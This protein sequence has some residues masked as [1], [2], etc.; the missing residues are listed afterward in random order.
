MRLSNIITTLEESIAKYGTNSFL[1]HQNEL[2]PSLIK[3]ISAIPRGS[4]GSY[5]IPSH[6]EERYEN[7]PIKP[8]V[9]SNIYN[10][11]HSYSITLFRLFKGS[12]MPLHDH[13]DISGINYLLSGDILHQS[14]DVVDVLNADKRQFVGIKYKETHLKENDVIVTLPHKENIHEFVANEN[15]SILQILVPDYDQ[16]QRRCSYW[17]V[18]NDLDNGIKHHSF[19]E[20]ERNKTIDITNLSM[21]DIVGLTII[22]EAKD[23]LDINVPFDG[24]ID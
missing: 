3:Q 16:K 5:R 19:V 21:N 7:V 9:W 14:Y 4:F 1:Y 18:D 24:L 8:I 20:L 13:P 6:A 12:R 15:T 17:E 2:F 10:D 22:P 23:K 11:G